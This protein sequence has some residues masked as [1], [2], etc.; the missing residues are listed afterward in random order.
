MEFVADFVCICWCELC[1]CDDLANRYASSD[2]LGDEIE[3]V[4]TQEALWQPIS[5][6]NFCIIIKDGYS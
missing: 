6:I 5:A 1:R 3:T 4:I 2:C